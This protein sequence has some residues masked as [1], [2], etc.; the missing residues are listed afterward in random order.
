MDYLCLAHTTEKTIMRLR[1]LTRD[2]IPFVVG[3]VSL[4]MAAACTALLISKSDHCVSIAMA[5]SWRPQWL[6]VGSLFV[7]VFSPFCT[8][9]PNQIHTNMCDLARPP[10]SVFS[11]LSRLGWMSTRE[12][13]TYWTKTWCDR[14][15]H[16][17]FFIFFVSLYPSTKLAHWASHIADK[18]SA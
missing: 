6:L 8:L 4:R 9:S 11:A 12:V 5:S 13:L 1:N 16:S 17:Y 18:D 3:C 7:S 2:W 14:R 15:N 10:L